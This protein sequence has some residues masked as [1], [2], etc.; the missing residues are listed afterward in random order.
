[1]GRVAEGEGQGPEAM[2]TAMAKVAKASAKVKGQVL[3]VWGGQCH[4]DHA[5][6]EGHGHGRQGQGPEIESTV[7]AKVRTKAAGPRGFHIHRTRTHQDTPGSP[8]DPLRPTK[9]PGG[10]RPTPI[11]MLMV[12]VVV[13]MMMQRRPWME[14]IIAT[15][16]Q[17]PTPDLRLMNLNSVPVITK[18][19]SM[20]ALQCI[21]Y[22][23]SSLEIKEKI[24]AT[25]A[26]RVLKHSKRAYTTH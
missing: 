14:E 19:N 15:V 6:A 9:S 20:A 13:M 10:K 26:R 4:D 25:H 17:K 5:R 12:M 23:G 22:L 16:Y 3:G 11:M 7:R 18:P 1:M 2:S 24:I 21:S 8:Q